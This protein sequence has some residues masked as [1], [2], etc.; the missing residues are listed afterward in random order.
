MLASGRPVQRQMS[1]QTKHTINRANQRKTQTT[2]L[3]IF[4]KK[5]PHRCQCVPAR[6]SVTRS[7]RSVSASSSLALGTTVCTR[8]RALALTDRASLSLVTLTV[9]D[10]TNE[11]VP[12]VPDATTDEIHD[13]QTRNQTEAHMRVRCTVDCKLC[14]GGG[15]GRQCDW[16][17]T[18]G[19]DV[20]IAVTHKRDEAGI[21]RELW[22][23]WC[24][25]LKSKAH[26]ERVGIR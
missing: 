12:G 8:A 17:C 15:R 3:Y 6:Q 21:V 16:G 14:G 7:S 22:I 9:S 2:T 13:T 19:T 24:A 23:H 5:E 26:Y 10:P 4:K 25:A 1:T 11:P 18:A 20:D